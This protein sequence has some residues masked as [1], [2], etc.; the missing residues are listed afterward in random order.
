MWLVAYVFI[1][2]FKTYLKT[3]QNVAIL[4]YNDEIF[5]Y[6]LLL[7]MYRQIYQIYTFKFLIIM[8]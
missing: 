6:F 8:L 7:N 5:L 2:E 4:E 1:I 3:V